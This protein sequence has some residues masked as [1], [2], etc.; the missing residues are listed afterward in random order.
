MTI[1][2]ILLMKTGNKPYRYLAKSA[3]F[4]LL[5]GALGACLWCRPAM[6]DESERDNPWRL[7]RVIL[8]GVDNLS[9]GSVLELMENRPSTIIFLAPKPLF[10]YAAMARDQERVLNLYKANGFFNAKVKVSPTY[11]HK[12]RLVDVTVHVDEGDRFHVKQIELILSNPDDEVWRNRLLGVVTLKTG[13]P[14]MIEEYANSKEAIGIFLANH[15]HPLFRLQ[16]QLAVFTDTHEAVARFLV[17]AGPQLM[18]GAPILHGQGKVG[19]DFVMTRLNFLSGQ[20][21]SSDVLKMT[22]QELLNTG[23]FSSVVV[24]PLFDEVKDNQV[25]I[26]IEWQEATP[27]TLALGLGWG[28]EDM[29]RVQISQVNRNMLGLNETLTFEGKYSDI[30]MGLIGNLG[31][32]VYRKNVFFNL[33]GGVR[34]TDNEAYND[35]SFFINPMLTY[36]Y[37][38]HWRAGLGFKGTLVKVLDVKTLVDDPEYEEDNHLINSIHFSISYDTRDSMLD[39][40]HGLL[41]QLDVEWAS[42][43]LGGNVS[44][45]KTIANVTNVIPMSW[46]KWALAWRIKYGIIAPL[47]STDHIPLV[48]RFFPGGSQSIRGYRYQNLG[49]LDRNSRPLGGEAVLEGSLEL[50]FPLVGELGGVLFV[51]AGNAYENYYDYSQTLRFTSGAGLR[52]ETPLGPIRLDFGYILN[53]PAEYEYSNYQVYLSVGQAF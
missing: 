34:Q 7:G 1:L 8:E 44:Y 11:I 43:A 49:P 21:F 12:D 39:A 30:Y 6:A 45:F 31:I 14:L 27:H 13:Q 26:S 18:F 19:D 32:P 22:Q 35:R 50:R 46:E 20:P 36:I 2:H 37:D 4:L 41:A 15:G 51:D 24:T 38:D 10:S 33:M 3:Y 23:L 52:Y 28:T 29:F 42:Q 25:P 48:C 47:E 17:D 40:T 16:G 53:P 9:H 5:L